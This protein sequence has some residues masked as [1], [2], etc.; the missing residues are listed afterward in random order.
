MAFKSALYRRARSCFMAELCYAHLCPNFFSGAPCNVGYKPMDV[1]MTHRLRKNVKT[2]TPN[3]SR[4]TYTVSKK[5]VH[6]LIF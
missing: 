3:L 1:T 6:I 2:S 4:C 5:S